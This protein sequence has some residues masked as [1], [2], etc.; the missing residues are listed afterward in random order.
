MRKVFTA[1]RPTWAEV[2]LK[3]L[4]SNLR[5]LRLRAGPRV[6]IMFVVKADAYGHGASA[7]AAL[8]QKRGLCEWFGV[9]SV[10]EGL[11]LR[12]A[13]IGLPILV[14][15]SLY[16]FESFAAAA[17]HQLT[18]TIASLEA[19]RIW[20][21]TAGRSGGSVSCHIKV[22]TGMGRIGMRPAAAIQAAG[23]IAASAGRSS[24]AGVYTHLSC[25]DK[26][27]A[28]TR[29][30]LS[31]FNDVAASVSFRAPRGFLRHAAASAAALKYPESRFDMIRP[32]L[33]AYGLCAGFKPVMSLKS[34]VVFIKTVPKG[35]AIGYEAFYRTKRTAR[36][37]TLPIGYA[38]G[39]ARAQSGG[40]EILIRGIRC[41][42]AGRATM[43]M[44]MVDVTAV[45]AVRVGD[46]AVIIGSQNGRSISAQEAARACGR[47]V[48]EMPCGVSARVPRIYLS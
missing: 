10:E 12:Y 4:A 18:P 25:P 45:P 44:T 24:L 16:P 30:Q 5:A 7:C 35:T 1:L 48:Y 36:I 42:V 20:A 21:K 2:D 14:L 19:A 26:S 23:E 8:A 15:G 47:I 38:D 27:P 28:F 37:A 3:A 6:K 32:G 22:E 39:L 34:R 41:P 9:S 17:R 13:G 11:V 40:G 33:A 46:E 29:R 43:D 31:V